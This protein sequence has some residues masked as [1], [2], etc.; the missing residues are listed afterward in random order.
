MGG[1]VGGDD[2]RELLRCLGTGI[3]A[4]QS[5]CCKRLNNAHTWQHLA[6]M[7]RVKLFRDAEGFIAA[8]AVVHEGAMGAAAFAEVEWSLK[9]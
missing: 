4:N 3:I 5:K 8:P 2:Q 6:K 1:V 7:I 9:A